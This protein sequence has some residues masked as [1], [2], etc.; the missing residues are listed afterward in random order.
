[1]EIA[2]VGR[3]LG[4]IWQGDEM[5]MAGR[6]QG[7][8]MEMAGRWPGDGRWSGRT[9]GPRVVAAPLRSSAQRGR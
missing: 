4:G 3:E 2:G 9:L 1:M 5:E 8:E 7:D 6:W